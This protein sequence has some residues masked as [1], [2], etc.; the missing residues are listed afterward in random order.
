MK[1]VQ[2]EADLS[3]GPKGFTVVLVPSRYGRQVVEEWSLIVG[4]PAGA[5]TLSHRIGRGIYRKTFSRFENL[6]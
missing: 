3:E 6:R 1:K 2:F 4:R 5:G